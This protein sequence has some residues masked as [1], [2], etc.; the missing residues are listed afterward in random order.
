[1][2]DHGIGTTSVQKLLNFRSLYSLFVVATIILN[3][4]SYPINALCR[5]RPGK[6]SLKNYGGMTSMT[7]SLAIQ[8]RGQGRL[9]RGFRKGGQRR[10]LEVIG[11]RTRGGLAVNIACLV[12]GVN[13][14]D[15]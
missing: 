8:P 4:L 1:M 9:D 15:K 14:R 3:Y 7:T 13:K 6:L 2:T 12:S 10:R 11:K 5:K